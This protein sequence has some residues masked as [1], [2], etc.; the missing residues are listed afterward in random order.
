MG[1]DLVTDASLR[2][3]LLGQLSEEQRQQIESLFMTDSQARERILFVEQDLIEDYL[4]DS[5]TA[6]ER[7]QFLEQYTATPEQRRKLRITKAIK[8]LAA[9]EK[10]GRPVVGTTSLWSRLRERLRPPLVLLVPLAAA[11]TIAIVS[12]AVWLNRRVERQTERSTIAREII[13]LNA[14]SNRQL[15]PETISLDLRPGTLRSVESPPQLEKRAGVEV[16]E[17]RLLWSL[18][19]QYSSY[20]AVV[21]RVGEEPLLVNDLHADSEGRIRLK[22]PAHIL[23][24]GAYRIELTGMG[25]GGATGA[26]EEYQFIVGG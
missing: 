18:K 1:D 5:L 16:V 11:I 21:Q 17:L 20:R 26:A 8:E 7:Q 4:D 13:Q 15:S 22:L 9:K 23:T 12:A 3:F 25:D 2:Q 19:D 24:R 6:A 14:P 10:A